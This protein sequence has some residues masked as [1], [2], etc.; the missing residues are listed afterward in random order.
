MCA[1]LWSNFSYCSLKPVVLRIFLLLLELLRSCKAFSVGSLGA[2][3]NGW[4]RKGP[5]LL[6]SLNFWCSYHQVPAHHH[7]CKVVPSDA[8][9][10]VNKTVVWG[11]LPFCVWH[12]CVFHMGW[13]LEHSW[14]FWVEYRLNLQFSSKMTLTLLKKKLH[15]SPLPHNL[16]FCCFHLRRKGVEKKWRQNQKK[17]WE[18]AA[19]VDVEFPREKAWA[20]SVGQT[21]LII[22]CWCLL[23]WG[24]FFQLSPFHFL[25]NISICFHQQF[26]DFFSFLVVRR[27][28]SLS[29]GNFPA[30]Q[31]SNALHRPAVL[32]G[33]RSSQPGHSSQPAAGPA[34]S[35]QCGP[36]AGQE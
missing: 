31:L 6:T 19:L 2:P 23:A 25:A 22:L 27:K 13:Q 29:I 21:V 35:W 14:K 10:Q 9:Y 8:K 15:I 18:C 1:L 20:G 3:P 5:K 32:L 12:Q 36:F 34:S 11:E 7:F 24:M 30:D 16:I 26:T 4:D 17:E 28:V 33:K